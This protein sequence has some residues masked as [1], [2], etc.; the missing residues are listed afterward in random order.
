MGKVYSYIRFSTIEQS[1]GNSLHRQLEA[2]QRYCEE[3]GLSLDDTLNFHDLGISAFK[4]VNASEGKLGAFIQAVDEGIL[5]LTVDKF[6][7][8]FQTDY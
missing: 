4:G 2:S 6:L 1:K 5:H 8:Q 3:N 7:K